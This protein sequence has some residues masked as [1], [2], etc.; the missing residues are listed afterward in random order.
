MI[1]YIVNLSTIFYLEIKKYIIET[2]WKY[3]CFSVLELPPQ[4]SFQ[5]RSFATPSIDYRWGITSV[6]FVK[7]P[8]PLWVASWDCYHTMSCTQYV[9]YLKNNLKKKQ[10]WVYQERDPIWFMGSRTS[11]KGEWSKEH[12]HPTSQMNNLNT[13]SRQRILMKLCQLMQAFLKLANGGHHILNI[14]NHFRVV[15]N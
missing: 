7:T 6:N 9:I 1:H 15:L 11:L 12:V 10:C 5:M 13:Q 14:L 8:K 2:R 4:V 3:D